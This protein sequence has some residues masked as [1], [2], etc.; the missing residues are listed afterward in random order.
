MS[1]YRGKG[2]I[3]LHYEM[4]S[5]IINE[6]DFC[7]I[8]DTIYIWWDGKYTPDVQD[9]VNLIGIML[10]PTTTKTNRTEVYNTI[11]GF[12]STFRKFAEVDKYKIAF[13]NGV[14]DL[15]T[16]KFETELLQQFA[17]CNKIPWNYNPD[18]EEQQQV[19]EQI[20]NGLIMMRTQNNYYIN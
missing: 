8:N 2:N 11:V 12:K 6:Y 10:D 7:T 4:A 9:K 3:F 13:E 16:M 15:S 19:R 5:D 17:V 20:K 18:P 1:R 14:L